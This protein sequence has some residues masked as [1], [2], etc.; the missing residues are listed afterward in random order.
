MVL[1]REIQIVCS[2]IRIVADDKIPFLKGAFEKEAQ[3]RYIPGAQISRGDLMDADVLITRTR[4]RCNSDLLEGTPVKYIATATI[5]YDHIDTKYCEIQGIE[6]T[7]APGCNSSSVQQYL[8]STLLYL[9][10]LRDLSPEKLTLGVIGVGNVGKKVAAAAEILGMRV[11]LNDP[12]RQ[13]SEKSQTF[14]ELD[15][16]LSQSDIVT[17]HVPLNR[18]GADN[19]FEMVDDGFTGMMKPGAV[20]V[21]TS[22][23]SVIQEEA[24]LSSLKNGKLS[25]V[26]LDVFPEEPYIGSDLLD[27]ITLVTPHIAGYSLD[28]KANGA[29]MSVQAVSRFFNLGLDFWTPSYITPPPAPELLADAATEKL[30]E[31]LWEV[32]RQS[33]DVTSDDRDLRSRPGEFEKLR[34]DY[35]IRREPP[36]FSVRL[37][38]GYEE[39]RIKLEQLGFSVL[40]D[41]CA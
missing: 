20:L 12:P 35:P 37:F 22:R 1:E 3:I 19:T 39:I 13:R 17:L 2:M 11:L 29:T 21:N 30:Y 23:G 24:L 32:Y 10:N 7:N 9:I 40:S 28:G 18:G 15:H 6:W 27:A 34:G 31:T 5:G 36:A 33:Y 25:D 16:L 8:V 26:I 41:H 4:T 38:Q 14:V